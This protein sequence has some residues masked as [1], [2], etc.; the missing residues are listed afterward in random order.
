MPLFYVAS[1]SLFHKLQFGYKHDIVWNIFNIW[2]SLTF[3]SLMIGR[4]K[5]STMTLF[6]LCSY[7]TRWHCYIC[8]LKYFSIFLVYCE[9]QI[10]PYD[11]LNDLWPG[12]K[13]THVQRKNTLFQF[14]L[15]KI[16][17]LVMEIEIFEVIKLITGNDP[18]VTF[19]L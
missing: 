15:K 1:D 3:D 8:H 17:C 18:L 9:S 5:T 11:P 4:T 14:K 10:W 2:P 12:W 16:L 19:D 6:Y 13:N 7:R